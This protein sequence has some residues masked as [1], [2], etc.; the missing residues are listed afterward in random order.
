MKSLFVS[1][2]GTGV[3]KTLAAAIV[4]EALNADYWKPVQAGYADGT[5]TDT[6]ASLLINGE[7]RTHTETYKLS[8][9]ASPHIAARK[10]NVQID[11]H[12]IVKGLKEIERGRDQNTHDPIANASS[13]EYLVIEGAGGLLVPLN[14]REFVI[15][16]A[17][18][19]K[20]KVILVSRNYLGSINHSLLSASLARQRNLDVLGWI[21]NDQYLAYEGEIAAWSGYPIIGSIPFCESPNRQFVYD[22][23]TAL[24]PRIHELLLTTGN[25]PTFAL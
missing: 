23:A 10:E 12:T 20:A 4:A 2:I 6:V 22:Q 17:A 9:P 16:I 15:D 24:R 3:G 1:G 14:D 25:S 7:A 13:S 5:D 18:E 11:V 19:I 21:F 8:M